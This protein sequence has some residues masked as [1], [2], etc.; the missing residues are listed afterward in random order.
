MIESIQTL[1]F[2]IT[3]SD[4]PKRKLVNKQA[5][6]IG[7]L[8]IVAVV[9]STEAGTIAAPD[10]FYVCLVLAG[11]ATVAAFGLPWARIPVVW[12][13]LIPVADFIAVGLLR[14]SVSSDMIGVSLLCFLPALW[15]VTLYRTPGMFLATGLALVCVAIPVIIREA[16]ALSPAVVLRAMMLTLAVFQVCWFTS[17]LQLW[18]ERATERAQQEADEKD[19]LHQRTARQ[20][21][22]LQN[23]IDT[24]DV[25]LVVLDRDGKEVL[26]NA[27][28]WVFRERF[29]PA[30]EPNAPESRMLTYLPNTEVLV[31]PEGRPLRRAA[32]LETFSNQLLAAGPLGDNQ[33]I[34]SASARQITDADGER[35][36]AVITFSDVTFHMKSA[37]SQSR[38]VSMVSHELRTPLTSIIGFL[39]LTLDEELTPAARSHLAVVQRNA[40]QLLVIVEDLLRNQRLANERLSF[41]LLPGRLS[42]LVGL[43]CDSIEAQANAKDVAIVRDLVPTPVAPLDSARLTQ[44]V[45]NLLSNAVKF[46]P[47][48]GTVTVR[49]EV[50]ETTMDVVVADTGIGMTPEEQ[51]LLYAQ[52]YRADGARARNIP[53]VGLGLA[54]TRDI[55]HGHGGQISVTSEAGVGSTFRVSLPLPERD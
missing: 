50:L 48:G 55:V 41:R 24:I 28:Q 47:S 30:D 25:G 35:D 22:L 51:S 13:G 40:E 15:L 17:G 53:G 34:L 7:L 1:W 27:A 10:L 37:H 45:D 14:A 42:E 31:P 2:R 16:S 23:I 36:G 26:R 44:V 12:S 19:A 54:I 4:D 9:L 49:T 20:E 3:V 38:F 11:I 43:A 18:L 21:R 39:D 33:L 32:N 8:L 29:L 46:T 5:L 52:F 6:F